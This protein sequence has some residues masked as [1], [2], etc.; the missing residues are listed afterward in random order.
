[1]IWGGLAGIGRAD[2]RKIVASVFVGSK[3]DECESDQASRLG[4]RLFMALTA[5]STVLPHDRTFTSSTHPDPHVESVAQAS[6]SG[7]F[8]Q[9]QLL[10]KERI[11]RQAESA[12]PR[13][14]S[15][16]HG[17]VVVVGSPG[18]G[19]LLPPLPPPSASTLAVA[20]F[21]ANLVVTNVVVAD[22]VVAILSAVVVGVAFV[23][24]VAVS[25]ASAQVAVPT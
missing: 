9:V 20:V 8:V 16:G 3:A 10:R 17:M 21:V 25:V 4:T 22:C 11:H 15:P 7:E 19:L 2:G 18:T 23:E 1:M 24:V 13:A 12:S 5:S 6:S 14:L